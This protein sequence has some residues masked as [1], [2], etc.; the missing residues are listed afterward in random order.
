MKKSIVS[1]V[2]ALSL[3]LCLF[4]VKTYAAPKNIVV[5][6]DPG[7][8]GQGEKH[9]GASY[10]GYVEKDLTLQVAKAVQQEL[11]KYENIT[12]YLTRDSDKEMSLAERADYAQQVGADFL[13]SIHF[14]ASSLHQFYGS[15][16]WTS[17]F[18]KFYKS[19]YE[20]G[21]IESGELASLGLYQK[22]V[23][24][25]LGNSGFDYYGIIRES[26]ARNM[27]AVIIEHS[28]LDHIY[29]SERL[30]E[31]DYIQKLG[32]ADATAIAKYFGLSSTS[33]SVDY[34]TYKKA[35]VSPPLAK[36][37]QDTTDPEKCDIK[38]L[39]YDR[40]SRNVLV[41]MTAYDRQSPIIYFSYSYDGGRTFSL[42][43]MWDRSQK[44]QSFNIHIPE[45]V[46]SANI[47][48]RSYNNYELF[49]Q[50]QGLPVITE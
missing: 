41:E 23:K 22:G 37:H 32:L 29:D 3:I 48:C 12:V 24:S 27:P 30:K 42:L 10:S 38:I 18:G 50:S 8:G 14:N 25:K 49:T 2:L 15:E 46:K 26:V 11:S 34:S 16:V 43:Q 21:L 45:V 35:S 33:L 44:T 4:P 19:G 20:F 5:V 47:V 7:H 40:E 17:A 13:F 1:W 39:S 9:Q 28:Y 6:L 36:V 31:P